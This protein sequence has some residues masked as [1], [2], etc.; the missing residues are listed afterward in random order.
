MAKKSDQSTGERAKAAAAPAAPT[1]KIKKT[2]NKTPTPANKRKADYKKKVRKEAIALAAKNPVGRPPDYTPAFCDLV[3]RIG[4]GGGS[5]T[6][7]AVTIGVTR[8]TVHKWIGEYE[9]FSYAM[10]RARDLSLLWWEN[11]GKSG[12]GRGHGFNGQ[13]FQFMAKNL[14]PADFRDQ[15]DI[16]VA[17]KGGGPLSFVISKDDAEL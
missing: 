17:G 13:T 2:T 5:L 4:E 12:M 11:A 8:V 16:E 9:E 15:K 10:T 6:E 14:F 7:M 1:R 3:I